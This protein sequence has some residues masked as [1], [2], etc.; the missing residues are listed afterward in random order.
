MI[1]GHASHYH[2]WSQAYHSIGFD[3]AVFNA[4]Q[5]TEASRKKAALQVAP[6]LPEVFALAGTILRGFKFEED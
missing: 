2:A 6:L 3:V 5:L 4:Q 1:T